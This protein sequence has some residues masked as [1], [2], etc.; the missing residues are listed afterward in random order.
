[1]PLTPSEKKELTQE[2]AA[3]IEQ[4]SGFLVFDYQGL[5]VGEI[6]DLRT[7][8][9]ETDS[10]MLVVKNRM[11]KR[12]VE[13]KPYSELAKLLL[14]PNAVVFAGEDPVMP[15]K[16]LVEFAKE[17]DKVEIRAGVVD[18][19][20]MDAKEVVTL[21]KI[22]S[23]DQLYANILG[24]IKAPASNILGCVKG[25]HNKLHGLMKAYAEKLDEAA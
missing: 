9:R 2:Y 24:G 7:K 13:D 18:N 19:I 25:L 23:K 14:G 8:I 4:A 3:M 1:M 10:K 21:S 15:A 20:Y 22:P 5:T 17:H 11:F 16:A 12:A 6:S